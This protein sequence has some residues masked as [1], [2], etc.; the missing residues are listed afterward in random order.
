MLVLVAQSC[1]TLCDPMDC[2]PPG[3]SVHEIFQARIL[4]CVPISSSRGSS[5][6]RDWT[7][8][9]CVTDIGRRILLPLSRLGSPKMDSSPPH[10]DSESQ[11]LSPLF[12]LSSVVHLHHVASKIT[13]FSCIKCLKRLLVLSCYCG[14]WTKPFHGLRFSHMATPHCKGR[15]GVLVTLCQRRKGHSLVNS[16]IIS[17]KCCCCC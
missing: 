15:P 16:E 3:S 1:P 17:D 13:L 11:I 8:V 4:E 5:W 7:P 9:S 2:N 6:P 12:F 14:F 10:G